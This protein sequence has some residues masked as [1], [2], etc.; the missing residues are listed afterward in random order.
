MR[1][2]LWLNLVCHLVS[3]VDVKKAQGHVKNLRCVCVDV[4]AKPFIS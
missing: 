4:G 2:Q 1:E 3:G